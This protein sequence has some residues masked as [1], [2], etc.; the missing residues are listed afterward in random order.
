MKLPW[1]WELNRFS[2]FKHFEIQ[3]KKSATFI[4]GNKIVSMKCLGN[5]EM[6]LF[7]FGLEI[8]V[9][10]LRSRSPLHRLISS[11][12]FHI[13]PGMIYSYFIDYLSFGSFEIGLVNFYW[14]VP[15]SDDASKEP[16]NLVNCHKSIL[17]G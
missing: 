8:C 2:I 12:Y 4:I 3:T 10:L 14:L 11:L 6:T 16:V 1:N 5:T 13:R 15:P 9:C 17:K 7:W